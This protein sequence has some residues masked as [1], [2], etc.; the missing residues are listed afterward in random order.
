MENADP[1]RDYHI[2]ILYKDIEEDNMTLLAAQC[3]QYQN[4][5]LQFINVSNYIKD[6]SFWT[7]NRETITVEAYFRLLIPEL[8]SGYDKVIYFDGDMICS[9]D[10]SVLYDV[11]IENYLL[12]SSRDIG[13]IGDYHNPK[14]KEQRVYN[15][16]VLKLDCVDNYFISGMLV[17]NIKAFRK[18]FTTNE[19]LDFAVSREWRAHDQD[20]LNVLC[21]GKTLLL[22]IEWDFF[23]G[24]EFE[25]YLPE[26]LKNEYRDTKL[27]PK[28]LHFPGYRK[29]WINGV[30]MPYFEYFWKY[31][32]RTPFIGVMLSRMQEQGLIGKT[33]KEHIKHDIQ[34]RKQ[35]GFR[36]IFGCFL[37]R[38][39]NDL[40]IKLSHENI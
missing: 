11:N 9:T 18:N 20:V 28:I 14:N 8:F 2:F 32:T 34:N 12:A 23:W 22:P 19:L 26:V 7:A 6:Y 3:R 13:A 31:A 30:Y 15:D 35:L 4:F 24:D 17:I 40:G 5:S 16:T 21:Q 1:S 10:V 39:K 37:A 25:P 33:Y 27:R 36:F 29:P 38:L